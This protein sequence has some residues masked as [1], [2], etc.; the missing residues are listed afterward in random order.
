MLRTTRRRPIVLTPLR[1]FEAVSRHLNFRIA[2]EELS[3]TQ[4]AVSRQIQSLEEDLGTTLFLRGTRHVELTS[5]GAQL[6]RACAP[7][8]DR[9]DA[10]VRQL[11]EASGRRV[12][13]VSTFASFATL[14]L[15]PRLQTFQRAHP[16]VDIRI[17]ASDNLVDPADGEFDVALR[18]CRVEDA[19]A[20]ATLLFGEVL[21]AAA[22]PWLIEDA[23][24]AG[25]SLKKPS[26][27]ALHNLLEEDSCAVNAE[28][29]S[30]AHWL[31]VQNL[32][33]LQPA[34]WIYFNYTHQQVQAAV[35]GQG[36]TL[37]RLPLTGEA[38][39]RGELVELFPDRR[40]DTD[41]RYW[42]IAGDPTRMRP[43][44]QQFCQFVQ[45]QAVLT[46]QMVDEA[47]AGSD[48]RAEAVLAASAPSGEVKAPAPREAA[49]A[50]PNA[51]P[52][53]TAAAR[54]G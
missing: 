9:L 5:A 3:L 32:P 46:R 24:K 14:W 4:S 36:I 51:R 18:H 54:K 29:I 47:L 52:R 40:I 38:I 34:R 6:L 12:V 53:L 23:R 35:A 11:R 27:L 17:S 2:A 19:P 25:L 16:D 43:E 30:W 45:E 44:V 41:Y 20:S 39:G 1:A 7:M 49:P 42:L 10:T 15:I 37:A 48:L 26:D 21:M 8:L 50:S 33:H 28:V 22:S 13:S 31:R